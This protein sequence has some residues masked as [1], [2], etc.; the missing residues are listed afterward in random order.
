[1]RAGGRASR[2]WPGR[3]YPRLVRPR[4]PEPV[5]SEQS[6]TGPAVPS[7]PR[8]GVEP[9]V[10]PGE[11]GATEI[12]A[13]DLRGVLRVAPFRKLW[14]ALSLSS[15]GDWLGLLATTALAQQL[16]PEQRRVVRRAELRRS[17]GC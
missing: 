5:I 9:A 13:H 11:A 17:A 8:S 6:Q 3:G 16:H 14:I 12:H 2:R 7:S 15:L 4:T 1:M 10:L